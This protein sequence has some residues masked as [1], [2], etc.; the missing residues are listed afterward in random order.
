LLYSLAIVIIACQSVA[1]TGER[2]LSLHANSQALSSI[3]V[4]RGQHLDRAPFFCPIN[5]EIP[6]PHVVTLPGLSG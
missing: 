1:K 3:F 4:H 6:R 5:D 2:S